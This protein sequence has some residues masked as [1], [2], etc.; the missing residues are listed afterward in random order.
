MSDS[1]FT[2]SNYSVHEFCVDTKMSRTKLY[3]LWRD[4]LGPRYYHIGRCKRI[5]HSA[6]L[7]WER[8]MEARAQELAAG[9]QS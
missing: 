6:R 4:G 7:E 2:T 8:E 9:D 3:Q 1:N 5:T